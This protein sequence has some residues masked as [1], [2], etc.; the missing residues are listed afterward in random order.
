MTKSDELYQVGKKV[1]DLQQLNYQHV[2][3][4]TILTV[5]TELEQWFGEN[6]NLSIE[7]DNRI[8]FNYT[9]SNYMTVLIEIAQQYG[10]EV[11]D[12]QPYLHYKTGNDF[13]YDYGV[14]RLSLLREALA[15]YQKRPLSKISSTWMNQVRVNLANMYMETGRIIESLDMLESCKDSFGMARINYAAKLYQLS[16][17]TLDKEIQKEFLLAASNYYETVISQ[18]SERQAYDPIPEDIF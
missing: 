15:L 3:L 14:K 18:Y 12:T 1:D 10:K 17:Y 7:D 11:H 16:F 4:N 5:I 8:I 6:N 13:L 9:K 2:E